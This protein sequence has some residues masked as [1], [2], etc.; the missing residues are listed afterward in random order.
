VSSWAL[1]T[2]YVALFG[3]SLG[4]ITYHHAAIERGWFTWSAFSNPQSTLNLTAVGGV[5]VAVVLTIRYLSWWQVSVTVFAG[6]LLMVVLLKM[7]R[8]GYWLAAYTGYLLLPYAL[9]I[10]R[11]L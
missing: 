11:P 1:Q 6:Y 3:I 5:F 8:Q 10:A 4:T 2:L 7:L 9:V